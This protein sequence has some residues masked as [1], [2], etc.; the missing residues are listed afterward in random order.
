[1]LGK[2]FVVGAQMFSTLKCPIPELFTK[3]SGWVTSLLFSEFQISPLTSENPQAPQ[4]LQLGFLWA[5]YL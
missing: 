2:T 1:M 4:S 3:T 5:S